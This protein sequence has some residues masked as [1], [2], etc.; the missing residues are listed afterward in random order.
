MEADEVK[1]AILC[2]V[3]DVSLEAALDQY[4]AAGSMTAERK[5]KNAQR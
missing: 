3:E 1:K 2:R 4:L 5:D